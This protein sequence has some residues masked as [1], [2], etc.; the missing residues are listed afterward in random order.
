MKNV[1]PVYCIVI[2]FL[3][4]ALGGALATHLYYKCRT[5][6]GKGYNG[7]QRE[8]RILNRLD[9]ELGLSPTQKEQVRGIVRETMKEIRQV[10]R[11]YRPQMQ[12]IIEKS[13]REVAVLLTPDQRKKF[14]KMI[15]EKKERARKRDY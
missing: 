14:E 7:Q 15:E 9:R 12:A 6:T 2:V 13:Q 4:G 8:E 10:R 3:L 5:D 1:R 11:Q